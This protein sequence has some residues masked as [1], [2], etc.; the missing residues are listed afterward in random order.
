MYVNFIF[1]MKSNFQRFVQEGKLIDFLFEP[2]HV[3]EVFQEILTLFAAQDSRIQ[4]I[5]TTIPTLALKQEIEQLRTEN[6]ALR[7]QVNGIDN[8]TTKRIDDFKTEFDKKIADLQEWVDTSNS[9]VLVDVRR[10]LN[11][12]LQGVVDAQAQQELKS[13]RSK[14]PEDSK[15]EFYQ[16]CADLQ[17]QI[18]QIF[19]DLNANRKVTESKTSNETFDNTIAS[20]KRE[21]LIVSDAQQDLLS[22]RLQLS[23]LEEKI[24]ILQAR[25][26]QEK[27]EKPAPVIIIQQKPEENPPIPKPSEHTKPKIVTVPQPE[28][29]VKQPDPVMTRLQS[30]PFIPPPSEDTA[31]IERQIRRIN[32]AINNFKFAIDALNEKV[33]SNTEKMQ[34]NNSQSNSK[35]IQ[36]TQ[37]VD[38]LRS[39]FERFQE[40]I[41]N[42]QKPTE[43]DEVQNKLV[44]MA[45]RMEDLQKS[46]QETD[47][48]ATRKSHV[49][50][51][52]IKY[53]ERALPPLQTIEIKDD[54]FSLNDSDSAISSTVQSALQS[55]KQQSPRET[56]EESGS[57]KEKKNIPAAIVTT[58]EILSDRRQKNT[59]KT[60]PKDRGGSI[61]IIRQTPGGKSPQDANINFMQVPQ[62]SQTELEEKV[63]IAI[64][65]SIAGF[66]D[67]AKIEAQKEVANGLKVV[68]KI[69][70]QI[71]TKIDRE[72]VDKMFNKFRVVISELKDKIDAIQCTFMGWVTR[73]ELEQ[74]LDKL[75]EQLQEVKDTAGGSS[76]FRCLLCGKPRTHISGML[77]TNSM[78]ELDDEDE[79]TEFKPK[80]PT[81]RSKSRISS[82]KIP[83][84]SHTPTV[85]RDVVQLLTSTNEVR[86]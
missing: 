38:Q 53:A 83:K 3:K 84:R 14:D 82:P 46:L 31:S 25:E 5:E 20:L 73:E 67:R 85:P 7:K 78:S 51:P 68:D 17:S 22:V 80:K 72:F 27:K 1:S 63:D 61:K 42:Q 24:A 41:R 54:D 69:S 76:K 60:S 37:D 28:P 47:A 11:T 74:V 13:S 33:Q 52:E 79:E 12:E 6:E 55:S 75:V 15:G 19:H 8:S 36:V 70:A 21:L 30:V 66:L 71:E 77:V 9:S 43:E 26:P 65:K 44:E 81:M 50:K 45:G 58:P 23:S 59:P 64:K 16:Q 48:K 57:P 18:D 32:E 2:E 49:V 4:Q 34:Y 39:Q 86:K 56:D 10:Y 35:Y 62:F 40:Q 29:Y